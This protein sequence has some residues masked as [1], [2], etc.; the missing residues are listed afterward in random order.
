MCRPSRHSR[1][2]T[3]IETLIAITL[4]LLVVL[5]MLSVVPYSFNSVQTNSIH[6]QAVAA[7]QQFL[8]DQRNAV[9]HAV[10]MPAATTVPI[11][12]GLAYM[13]HGAANTNYGNFTVT[14]DGCTTVQQSGS[15][16]SAVNLYSCSATVTWTESGAARTVTVQSYV[17]ASK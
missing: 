10:A 17:I 13:G 16:T 4:L 2:F 14:P 12:P 11:D 15:V 9:L 5:A 6:V 8:D 1:A 3:L 7:G